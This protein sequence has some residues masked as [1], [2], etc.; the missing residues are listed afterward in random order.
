MANPLLYETFTHYSLPTYRRFRQSLFCFC[1]TST[2]RF[3]F[4]AALVDFVDVVDNE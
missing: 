4:D 3:I 1:F 2:L